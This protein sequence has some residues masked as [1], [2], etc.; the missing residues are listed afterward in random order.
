MGRSPSQLS[1]RGITMPI[2][3]LTHDQVCELTGAKTKK[4]QIDNLTRNSIRHS[5]KVSGWPALLFL[6]LRGM[7][8]RMMKNPPRRSGVLISA[9]SG[10][11]AACD[12][13]PLKLPVLGW[14]S[15]DVR[16]PPSR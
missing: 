16:V 8:S 4:A 6:Q 13:F 12:P 7:R 14:V 3:F 5:I 15:S 10:R 11:T 9:K 2:E 1:I